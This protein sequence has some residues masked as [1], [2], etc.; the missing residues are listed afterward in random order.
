MLRNRLGMWWMAAALAGLAACGDST[1]ND[2]GVT[3]DAAASDVDAAASD[4]DAAT[5]TVDGGT[6]SDGGTEDAA[7][8][9]DAAV[10]ADD[11]ATVVTETTWDDVHPDLQS[12]CAPCHSTGSSGG[13][14]FARTNAD[15]AYAD[16]QESAGSC[17]GLTVGACAAQRVRAGQM[18]PGGGLPAA[19]R[20]AL[21]DLL[22]AWVADGQVR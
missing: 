14:N 5:S 10:V 4:L 16:S 8:S 13:T 11:A 3:V 17:S 19:Q 12:R 21:A 18:P 1:G 15:D 22:D 9:D 2:A 20:T 6:P 7:A